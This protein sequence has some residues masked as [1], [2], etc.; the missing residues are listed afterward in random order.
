ME[1]GAAYEVLLPFRRA[2]QQNDTVPGRY[3]GEALMIRKF[4]LFAYVSC[5]YSGE[6][7]RENLR[8]SMFSFSTMYA[9]FAVMVV[10]LPVP[11]P[12]SIKFGLDIFCMASN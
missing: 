7:E 10:V 8:G 4:D 9:I 12:A 6:G 5:G 2:I 3:T 11:A 1:Q